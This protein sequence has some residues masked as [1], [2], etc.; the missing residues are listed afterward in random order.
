M[1]YQEQAANGS[2]GEYFFAFKISYLLKWP[3]RLLDIDIGI[4][5]QVEVMDAKGDS[6][7]K[8]VAFQIKSKGGGKACTCYVTEAQL[9]YWKE[10]DLPVF[11]TLV[12]LAA[13]KIYIHRVKF[14]K[15]YHKTKDGRRRIDFDLDKDL[16]KKASTSTIAGAAEEA[17]RAKVQKSLILVWAAIERIDTEISEMPLGNLQ[18]LLETVRVRQGFW[19]Q[20]EGAKHVAEAYRVGQEMCDSAEISLRDA[21]TRLASAMRSKQIHAD[22]DDDGEVNKFIAEMRR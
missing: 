2:A 20:L 8:F 3:C 21:L 15:E 11:V 14:D 9:T 7:G 12:H 22:N 6:T 1:K 10:L 13:A 5:A 16:L 19:R 17:G 4:D 18:D